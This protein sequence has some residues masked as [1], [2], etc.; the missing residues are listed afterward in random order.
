MSGY[1]ADLVESFS[2]EAKAIIRSEPYRKLFPLTA[3]EYFAEGNHIAA[4]IWNAFDTG[5]RTAAVAQATRQIELL[6]GTDLPDDVEYQYAVFEQAL[7]VLKTSG[8]ALDHDHNRPDFIPPDAESKTGEPA[9]SPNEVCAAALA[10]IHGLSAQGTTP[11]PV[12][13][14]ERG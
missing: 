11:R 6:L 13:T 1:G 2:K 8:V 7:H 14:L 12:V 10:W 9:G 3:D 5:L 4:R